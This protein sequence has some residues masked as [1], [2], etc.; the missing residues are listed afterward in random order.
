MTAGD[1]ILM[2]EGYH[3]GKEI[4]IKCMVG[5]SGVNDIKKLAKGD[6]VSVKGSCAGINSGSDISLEAPSCRIELA[7]TSGEELPLHAGS[8]RAYCP[9]PLRERRFGGRISNPRRG[10]SGGGVWMAE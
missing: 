10:S 1:E 6:H 9:S 8:S 5:E 3:D 7:R 4:N 2:L